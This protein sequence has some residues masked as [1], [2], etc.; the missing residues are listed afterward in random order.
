MLLESMEG[1]TAAER[2]GAPLRAGRPQARPLP[3][4]QYAAALQQTAA[5]SEA[6]YSA[7][8]AEAAPDPNRVRNELL[9]LGGALLC[10]LLVAPALFWVAAK[11]V[12]GPYTHGTDT[13]P[14]GV[15]TLLSDFFGLLAHGSPMAWIVALGPAAML[16][17]GRLMW[18]LLRP[19]PA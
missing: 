11:H 17:F 6:A 15:G 16:T 10:G 3:R 19:R 8:A 5:T 18:S 13:T 12:I 14:L 9:Y 4:P 2:P 1:P 7:A